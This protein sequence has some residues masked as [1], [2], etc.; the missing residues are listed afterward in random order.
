LL[1]DA[2]A[3]LD[4]IALDPFQVHQVQGQQVG[5]LSVEGRGIRGLIPPASP[6]EERPDVL[7]QKYTL[8][9]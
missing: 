6:V 3:A 5:D 9:G 4:E 8:A 7:D 1:E 2:E